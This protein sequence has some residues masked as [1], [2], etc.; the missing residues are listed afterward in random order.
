ML[1]DLVL[2][3]LT[4][5]AVLSPAAAFAALGAFLLLLRKPSERVVSGVVLSSLSI[6]LA[7]S[8]VVWGS[9]RWS[10]GTGSRR[11]VTRS[12]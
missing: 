7:A 2:G 12:T 1:P 4:A 11:R 3:K 10:S 5:L 6:S 8:L 9:S